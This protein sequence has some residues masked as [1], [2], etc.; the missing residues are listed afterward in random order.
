MGVYDINPTEYNRKLAEALKEIEEFKA[1]E[2]M[3]YVKTGSGKQRPPIDNDFWYIRASSILRQI[4]IKK[5]VGV[6]RLKTRY[7][8]RKDRGSQPG[9]F[10]KASGKIIRLI[11]QQAEKAGLVEKA[12]GKKS[13]RKLTEKGIKLLDSIK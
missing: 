12:A 3:S 13:G 1:P 7:G 11:L 6:E 10:R 4:Y 2:F 9:K 5:T 8:S